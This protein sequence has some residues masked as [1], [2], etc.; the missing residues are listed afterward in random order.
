MLIV[1]LINL[2]ASI[3]LHAKLIKKESVNFPIDAEALF[4][5]E[6]HYFFEIL[7]PR[8]LA[9]QYPSLFELDSLALVQE[10]NVKMVVNKVV[11]IVN[12][13]VGFFDEKQMLDEKYV[14]H[15]MGEQKVKKLAGDTFL[16]TVPGEAGH[17][18]KMQSFFDADDLST[19]PTSKVMRAVATV[20]KLDV[21]SQGANTIMFTEKTNFT[22]YIEGGVS[23]SSYIPMKENKTLIITYNL[24]AAKTPFVLPK[25]LRSSFLKEIVAV[26]ELQES[27]KK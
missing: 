18:Y 23:V 1:F 27:F 25:V 14:S 10:N 4:K 24:Y 3:P 2:L 12:K 13:P 22:K 7:S 26:K 9:V 6:T 5:G 11:S 17:S 21:I 8:E 19:L 20:K 16:I 15:V